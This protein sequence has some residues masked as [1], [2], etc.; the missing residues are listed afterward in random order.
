MKLNA[1]TATVAA[2]CAIVCAFVNDR[3]DARTLQELSL[4]GVKLIALQ[5]A[6]F[7]HVDLK[8]A[9]KLGIRVVRVP[10]YSPHA[11]AEHALLL[12]LALN[13]KI[14]RAHARVREHNF[15]LEGLV[16]FDLYGK[17]VGVVGT[18]KI[19]TEMAKILTGFGCRVLAYDLQ[20]SEE[21]KKIGVVYRPLISIYS[22]ADILSLHIPLNDHTRHILDEAAFSQMKYG[23]MIINTS[24]GRLIDTK[25][26]VRALKSGRVGS[27]GLD[28][29]EEEEN[30]FFEDHSDQVLQDD[31]L[32]RLLTFPNVLITAHQAFLTHEALQNIAETTLKSV[33]DFCEGRPLEF[34]VH[35]P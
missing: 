14:L 13:R 28:V 12:I 8:V 9:G 35:A 34:E 5:S 30:L 26:L 33:V 22:E 10:A 20:E 4:I 17:T 2:G 29:Y 7:N 24:R 16:G 1:E 6:G 31:L 32:A 27:A 18:G 25:A 19:G 11:V 21:L 3:L 23:A 15:S